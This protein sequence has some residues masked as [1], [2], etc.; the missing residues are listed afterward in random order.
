MTRLL[1][2]LFLLAACPKRVPEPPPEARALLSAPDGTEL[3]RLVA[4]PG[5][6][7]LELFA[8]AWGRPPGTTWHMVLRAGEA[9]SGQS[10]SGAGP[11]WRAPGAAHPARVVLEASE[12]GV[13][14][15]RAT[16]R[17]LTLVGTANGVLGRPVLLLPP[18]EDPVP[19][20][21]GVLQAPPPT[22]VQVGGDQ[23]ELTEAWE[24]D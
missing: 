13:A 7:G 18:G 2:L 12:R 23:P 6:Q 17:G 3:G 15:G 11:A 8:H 10:F 16:D 4:R 14:K 20:A 19:V 1:P 22:E 24:I 9:C 5:D 21:C